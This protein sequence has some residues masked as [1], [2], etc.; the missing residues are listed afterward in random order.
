MSIV[1]TTIAAGL[2]AIIMA[3]SAS[4]HRGHHDDY[5]FRFDSG[6]YGIYY[7][8]SN[9]I[10]SLRVLPFIVAMELLQ[11]DF[12]DY[13]HRYDN[14][15]NRQAYWHGHGRHHR[16]YYRAPASHFWYGGS[17]W[18]HHSNNWRTHF[19]FS[20]NLGWQRSPISIHHYY[21]SRPHRY[22]SW[23]SDG[24]FKQRRWEQRRERRRLDRWER[25][26]DNRADN[27][28]DRRRELKRADRRLDRREDRINDRR[29][30]LRDDRRAERRAERSGDRANVSRKDR[31]MERAI[32]SRPDGRTHRQAVAAD[33]RDKGRVSD[34]QRIDRANDT[35]SRG[36]AANRRADRIEANQQDRK[37]RIR[38]SFK[39]QDSAKQ[40]ARISS[41]R[42]ERRDRPQV[43]GRGEFKAQSVRPTPERKAAVQPRQYKKAKRSET[44]GEK[45]AQ[46][47]SDR[48]SDRKNERRA[49][50]RAERRNN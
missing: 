49:E 31:R 2:F 10:N 26:L 13:R 45:R 23:V 17:R 43:S 7:L 39:G 19:G 5:Y 44:R 32:D 30:D 41:Q 22:S 42:S 47:K 18:N 35:R 50:R 29:G 28:R 27:L 1:R 24:Y 37:Q 16:R 3:G 8:T 48:R 4:A 33:R 6:Q 34:R 14:Y 20:L 38:K 46:R 21:R 36:L 12:W 9:E 40:K 11:N 25:R 15:H